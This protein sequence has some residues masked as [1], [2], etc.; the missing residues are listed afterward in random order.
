MIWRCHPSHPRAPSSCSWFQYLQWWSNQWTPLAP[1]NHMRKTLRHLYFACGCGDRRAASW[2]APRAPPTL[3]RLAEDWICGTLLG[4]SYDQATYRKRLSNFRPV[5]AS[6]A[7][8]TAYQR[9]PKDPFGS[10][11]RCGVSA[12]ARTRQTRHLATKTSSIRRVY[13]RIVVTRC[14]PDNA[15]DLTKYSRIS[16][17][18]AWAMSGPLWTHASTA[19]LP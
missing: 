9:L 16:P 5:Y 18:A 6:G 8:F 12:L 7:H 10:G 17:P 19:P 4:V 15:L 3:S 11:I 1:A 2:S 14:T 13:A